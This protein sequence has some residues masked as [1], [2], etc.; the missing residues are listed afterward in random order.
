MTPTKDK[1]IAAM[2]AIQNGYIE[3]FDDVATVEDIIG[4]EHVKT[5]NTL[6]DQAINAP[7]LSAEKK[8]FIPHNPSNLAKIETM[9]YVTGWNAAINHL[10]TH[11]TINKRGV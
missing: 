9:N 11:Y 2:D 8:I 1:L 5:L 6:L 3:R 10:V 7:D 4:Q